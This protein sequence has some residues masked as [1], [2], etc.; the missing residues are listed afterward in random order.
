MD[1]STKHCTNP[2]DIYSQSKSYKS[3][4]VI[5]NPSLEKSIFLRNAN[6]SIL[7]STTGLIIIMALYG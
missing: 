5:F 2:P 1:K 3:L 4:P 7:L 6:V